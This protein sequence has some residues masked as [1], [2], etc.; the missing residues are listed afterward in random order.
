MHA[1]ILLDRRLVGVAEVG[2]AGGEE[3]GG[4]IRPWATVWHRS[5]SRILQP[6]GWRCVGE[7]RGEWPRDEIYAHSETTTSPTAQL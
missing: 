6:S 1:S 5:A 4:I 2:R 7:L 3:L